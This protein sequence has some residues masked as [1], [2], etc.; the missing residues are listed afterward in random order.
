MLEVLQK[1]RQ[2]PRELLHPKCQEPFHLE[3]HMLHLPC[4]LKRRVKGDSSYG[5]VLCGKFNGKGETVEQG[6][7]WQPHSPIPLYCQ[8]CLKQAKLWEGAGKE[9]LGM[10]DNSWTRAI[11]ILKLL[12]KSTILA[13]YYDLAKM[14]NFLFYYQGISITNCPDLLNPPPLHLDESKRWNGEKERY[15]HLNAEF[16]RTA[17]RD[18]KAFLG[19]Q[20][21][22][23]EETVE[24]GRLEISSR[25]LEIPRE[26]FMQRWAQ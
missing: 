14:Q 1:A 16:Q 4:H 20:C 7:P 19:D 3:M 12:F 2:S 26:H 6:R 10:M 8:C 25:K 22:E 13:G 11:C 9:G 18:K 21:K 24:W 23:I 5:V 17:R 15:T